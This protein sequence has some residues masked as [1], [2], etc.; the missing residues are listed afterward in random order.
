MNATGR[1]VSIQVAELSDR[2]AVKG[3]IPSIVKAGGKADILLTSAGIQKRH[4]SEKFPDDDW[5]EVSRYLCW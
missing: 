1:K 2:E 3:I 5:D 4:P